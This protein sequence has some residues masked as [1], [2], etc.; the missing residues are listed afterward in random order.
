MSTALMERWP[1]NSSI[2]AQTNLTTFENTNMTNSDD[3]KSSI[4][5]TPRGD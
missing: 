4:F 2:T 3:G 5:M 1:A